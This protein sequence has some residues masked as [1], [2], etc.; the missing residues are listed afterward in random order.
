MQVVVPEET[1]SPRVGHQDGIRAVDRASIKGSA[2]EMSGSG[3]WQTKY[4]IWLRGM[5]SWILRRVPEKVRREPGSNSTD[6]SPCSSR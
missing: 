6:W 3:W 1:L 2:A 4:R 5:T